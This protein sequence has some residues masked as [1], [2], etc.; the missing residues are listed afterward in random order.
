MIKTKRQKTG[1]VQ[2]TFAVPDGGEDV[3]FVADLNQ[4]EPVP[5][6]KRSNGTRS[7][8]VTVPEG[9]AVRFRYRT[10]SGHW[11]DDPEGDL[12][13]NGFGETHTLITV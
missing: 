5:L 13:P 3:L 7:L 9:S 4:W 2:V 10:A 1:D 6:K 11:F 12:E 8:A